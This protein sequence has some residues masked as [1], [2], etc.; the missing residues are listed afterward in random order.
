MSQ[1]PSYLSLVIMFL[2][3]NLE[4]QNNELG[5]KKE[6]KPSSESYKQKTPYID[7]HIRLHL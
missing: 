7:N 4:F 2:S 3:I 6:T 1:K 5:L